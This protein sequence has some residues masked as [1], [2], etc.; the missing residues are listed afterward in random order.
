MRKQTKIMRVLTVEGLKEK[1]VQNN[2]E[3]C[4]YLS[5]VMARFDV[6]EFTDLKWRV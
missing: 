2:D 6:I 3:A 5:W 4:C 1:V